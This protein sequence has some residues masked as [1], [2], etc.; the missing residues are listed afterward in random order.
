MFLKASNIAILF[1]DKQ[2][3]KKKSSFSGWNSRGIRNQYIVSRT[4]NFFFPRFVLFCF[5]KN[6]PPPLFHFLDFLLF[7]HYSSFSSSTHLTTVG[8]QSGWLIRLDFFFKGTAKFILFSIFGGNSVGAHH[9]GVDRSCCR[10]VMPDGFP[11]TPAWPGPLNYSDSD[12][13]RYLNNTRGYIRAQRTPVVV[14]S[15]SFF[16]FIPAMEFDGV[17]CVYIQPRLLPLFYFFPRCTQRRT[18]FFYPACLICN[19]K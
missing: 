19:V 13:R 15:S 18:D 8:R 11:A 7:H 14:V 10:C 2:K 1:L 12:A 3:Q 16:F 17:H 6:N 9:D 5:S 4:L